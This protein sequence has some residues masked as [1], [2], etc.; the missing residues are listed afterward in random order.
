MGGAGGGCRRGYTLT[1][2]GKSTPLPLTTAKVG[3]N[4]SP[5]LT[6]AS[7]TSPDW[8]AH[9]QTGC[10]G[11][12]ALTVQEQCRGTTLCSTLSIQ[13]CSQ[14]CFDQK[15]ALQNFKDATASQKCG[16]LA[17]H[18]DKNS[19]L[20]ASQKEAVPEVNICKW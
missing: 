9:L 3:N 16:P 19:K 11:F 6:G 13:C 2:T 8:F 1:H 5:N 7:F 12:T 20:S 10:Q 15:S 17:Y 4:N 18:L 14:H